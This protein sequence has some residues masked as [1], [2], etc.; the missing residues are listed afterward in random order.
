MCTSV[1]QRCT[2]ILH[3]HRT[4]VSEV[5]TGMVKPWC[6]VMHIHVDTYKYVRAR[7]ESDDVRI[8]VAKIPQCEW[9][10]PST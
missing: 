3:R 5:S 7:S 2:L 1:V 8:T 10:C 6:D 4:F 9:G